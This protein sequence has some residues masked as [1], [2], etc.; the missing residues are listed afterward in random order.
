[1]FA[2]GS[3]LEISGRYGSKSVSF[4]PAAGGPAP[5]TTGTLTIDPNAALIGT[6]SL[7]VS[8]ML[9]LNAGAT[10]GVAGTVDANGGVALNGGKVTVQGTTLNI[11]STATWN[12]GPSA[13]IELDAE[14]VIN[15]LAGATFSTI[16]AYSGGNSIQAGDGSA[17]AFN[18]AG[19]F[20]SSAPVGVTIGVPFVNTGSVV[21]Q[22][23][24]LDV[25]NFTNSGTATVAPGASLNGSGSLQSS[26]I[27]PAGDTLTTTPGETITGALIL[28]GGTLEMT[29]DLTIVGTLVLENASTVIGGGGNVTINGSMS[30]DSGTI[31]GLGTLTIASGATLRLGGPQGSIETLDGLTLNNAG[32]TVLSGLTYG[33]GIALKHGA[34]IDNLP[35]GKF[36][37]QDALVGNTGAYIYS[38]GSPTFFRNESC[39]IVG[40]SPSPLFPNIFIGSGRLNGLTV[41]QAASFT[42]TSTGLTVLDDGSLE[43]DGSAMISGSITAAPGTALE[44]DGPSSSFDASSSLTS[45]GIVVLENA[46]TVAGAYD[47]TGTTFAYSSNSGISFTARITDLS[48]AFDLGAALVVASAPLHI[49]AS[50]PLTFTYLNVDSVSAITGAGGN[51]TVT[52]SMFWYAGTISGFGTL[53]IAG[54]ATLE[55]SSG[56]DVE[57]ETL[58]GVTLDNAGAATLIGNG[59]QG[60]ALQNGA[61]FVNEPGA[62]FTILTACPITSDGTATSFTNEGS[63]IDSASAIG[64]TIIQPSFTQTST[65]TL[66]VDARKLILQG[67]GS[68]VTNAGNI[69]VESGG[70]LAVSTDYDQTAGST[71]LLQGTV[72]GGN[73]NIQGAPGGAPARSTPM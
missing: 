33:D 53:A 36:S 69:T 8:G 10:L 63:L 31:S 4:A 52:G 19:T 65:G 11:H 38:D 37:F 14:A 67:G 64:Q 54:G 60:L 61:E 18:N 45:A 12:L 68:P 58:N 39:L 47:V 71:T 56:Y 25:P 66:V 23:G 48:T 50:V 34:G 24:Y 7:Q 1:M 35:G 32:T 44:F 62:S 46:V 40:G 41:I 16:G 55:L 70:T 57:T 29:G 27:V 51:L 49:A 5:L 26:V 15:D 28:A 20:T 30:W 73:L 21:V 72:S 42:Q 13:D 59:G 6:V 3:S 43:F 2:V 17:V 22:Q 9:N